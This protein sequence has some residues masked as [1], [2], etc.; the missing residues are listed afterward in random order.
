MKGN[1]SKTEKKDKSEYPGV[2]FDKKLNRFVAT[3]RKNGVVHVATK[4]TFEEA[5]IAMIEFKKG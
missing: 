3:F 2:K 1:K 5:K 4:D